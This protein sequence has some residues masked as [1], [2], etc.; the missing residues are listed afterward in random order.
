MAGKPNK[1]NIGSLSPLPRIQIGMNKDQPIYVQMLRGIGRNPRETYEYIMK[2]L[3]RRI[4]SNSE[5][6]AGL[7][8]PY[9]KK[10]AESS[11]LLFAMEGDLHIVGIYGFA[12][13]KMYKLGAE[14]KKYFEIDVFC[15]KQSFKG[16]GKR[17]MDEIK[18]IACMP[19]N[20]ITS[21]VLKSTPGA[22]GFYLSQGF[23][24]Y[25]AS[26]DRAGLTRMYL[27]MNGS[28]EE[29]WKIV[30]GFGGDMIVPAEPV[31]PAMSNAGIGEPKKSTGGARHTR[32]KCKTTRKKK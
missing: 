27:N 19:E 4:D 5:I 13:V 21:I 11:S 6:C 23:H 30:P 29:S 25:D 9:S 1:V 16:I 17:I 32:R 24:V 22:I 28:E 12:T 15:T 8:K 20:S 31:A 3:P 10:S 2:I 7:S 26:P 18:K 14:Q